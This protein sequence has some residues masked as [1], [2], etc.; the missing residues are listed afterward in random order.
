M[1]PT[2]LAQKIKQAAARAGYSACG[3]TDTAPFTEFRVA[4]ERRMG[5][6]PETAHLYEDLLGRADPSA[7][8]PWARTI[9]ACVRRYGK[10]ALPPGLAGHIGRNYLCDRRYPECPDYPMP[11]KF[12]QSLKELGLRVARGGKRSWPVVS[13]MRLAMVSWPRR[14]A[15]PT[16]K[17]TGTT[18]SQSPLM[19]HVQRPQYAPCL[20]PGCAEARTATVPGVQ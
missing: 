4:V 1:N 7:R 3:I 6:F 12:K 14:R 2:D 5:R 11:R 20:S 19:L 17:G 10:Y 8:K 9:V 15:Q 13:L 18:R 16:I